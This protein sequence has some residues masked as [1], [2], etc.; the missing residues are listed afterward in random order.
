MPAD[1]DVVDAHTLFRPAGV[2]LNTATAGLPPQPAWQAL[3]LAWAQYRDGTADAAG[4]DEAVETTR[5]AFA[6]LMGVDAAEVA[7]GNQVSVFVGML[8]GALPAGAEVLLAEGDFTSVMF[9]FLAQSRLQVRQVPLRELASAITE[10]TAMVAVSAVQSSSGE[11]ADLDGIRAACARTGTLSL[12]DATQAAG[13]LPLRAS[14]FDL[15]VT[16]GYKFLL[17]PRGTAFLTIRPHLMSRF[18]P[19]LANWYA[20]ADRWSSIYGG[21]LRL[22]ESARRY[23]LSPAWHSWIG[24]APAMQLLAGYGADALHRHA[25]GLANAFRTGVGL[26]ESNSAIVSLGQREGADERIRAA[27]IAAAGRAG[28]LRVS[29]HL[30][31]SAA[32]VAA[33]V[34]ALDGYVT[35]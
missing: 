28:R 20:G 23:D 29:F 35:G 3:E 33:A 8:A 12:I 24:A 32:D 5:S 10:Q 7:A 16:G 27:G 13:W 17:A 34:Q 18:E 31:N 25:V 26:P 11:V 15:T 19:A 9:P 14:D 2:Y 6:D 22:A 4:F 21:P 1:R 30:N